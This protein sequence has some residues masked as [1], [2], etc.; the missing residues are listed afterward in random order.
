MSQ[1]AMQ[2]NDTSV[3]EQFHCV[4]TFDL[5]NRNNFVKVLP[6]GRDRALIR[7]VLPGL[8][9]RSGVSLRVCSEGFSARGHPGFYHALRR[10]L[11]TQS[12]SASSWCPTFSPPTWTCTSA[13]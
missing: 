9:R 12:D 1:L 8:L 5:L 10:T 2:Y 3:L 11:R 13:C 6:P 4:K 7:A